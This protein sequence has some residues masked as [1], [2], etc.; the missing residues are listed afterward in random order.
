MASPKQL[1]LLYFLLKNGSSRK[2]FGRAPLE[3]PE[4][5][6]ERSPAKHKVVSYRVEISPTLD[7]T[8]L[9]VITDLINNPKVQQIPKDLYATHIKLVQFVDI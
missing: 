9:L 4:P 6:P 3:E 1:Q 7:Y 2:T 8:R 5:E